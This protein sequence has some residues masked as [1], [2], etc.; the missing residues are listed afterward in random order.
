M[1]LLI[2]LVLLPLGL[3]VDQSPDVITKEGQSLTLNC[4]QK[5]TSYNEMYWYRQQRGGELQLI[6]YFYHQTETKEPYFES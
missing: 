2:L 1:S 6:V 3:A 4:S 5:A